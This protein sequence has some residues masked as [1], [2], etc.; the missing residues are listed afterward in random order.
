MIDWFYNTFGR[1]DEDVLESFIDAEGKPVKRWVRTYVSDPAWWLVIGVLG[2]LAFAFILTGAVPFL[3]GAYRYFYIKGWVVWPWY[4][5]IT[6]LIVFVFGL[7]FLSLF[8]RILSVHTIHVR[9]DQK[10]DR[11]MFGP[12]R[13]F[14]NCPILYIPGWTKLAFF[15][16]NQQKVQSAQKP[17]SKFSLTSFVM[18]KRVIRLKPVKDMTDQDKV[19]FQK[20]TAEI[21]RH[22]QFFVI[23]VVYYLGIWSL[24]RLLSEK[25]FTAFYKRWLDRDKETKYDAMGEAVEEKVLEI[26]IGAA[27]GVIQDF[28][29]PELNSDVKEANAELTR[30][31]LV[32]L[33]QIGV[34]LVQ[35]L[36]VKM[37]DMPGEAGYQTTTQ[38]AIRAEQKSVQEQ[39]EAESDRKSR[40]KRASENQ[41]AA[42]KE[43]EARAKIAEAEAEALVQVIAAEKRRQELVNQAIIERMKAVADRSGDLALAKLQE[44]SP[45]QISAV[46]MEV[47]RNINPNLQGAT[48]ASVEGLGEFLKNLPAYKL[49]EALM[50]FFQKKPGTPPTPP[51]TSP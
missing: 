18:Q 5:W 27:D 20:M 45:E 7:I 12:N 50:Q 41:A 49:L 23:E 43:Q 26:S 13:Y 40:E 3:V 39:S 44:M 37:E 6:I 10:C 8:K 34:E 9:Q 24:P 48:L 19:E 22:E 17:G 21:P 15:P 32:P 47:A 46:I 1:Y 30:Q 42:E 16:G 33:R 35:V 11:Q 29:A 25:F 14:R 2:L 36:I 38:K 28:S 31:L 51:P 4:S